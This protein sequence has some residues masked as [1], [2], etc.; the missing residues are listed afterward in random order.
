MRRGL[1]LA[2]LAA[3]VLA[4]P[5][6]AKTGIWPQPA[7]YTARLA[8]HPSGDTLSGG[9]RIQFVNQGPRTLRSVYL[10]V[11][12]NGYGSCSR[13][14]AHVRVMRGGT[15]AGWSVGCTALRV[16]FAH[17]LPPGRAHELRLTLGVRVPST[18]NRFGQDAGVVYL[19]N[20][21]PLLA[22]DEAAGPAL[23]PYTDLGDPFYSLTASWSV[24]LD[25]PAG[26]TAA[27][28]GSQTSSRRIAHGYRRLS[29][30]AAHARDFAIVIGRLSMQWTRAS[31]G[32]VL[33]RYTRAGGD[34]SAARA[35]LGMARKAIDTYTS[36]FGPLGIGEIDLLPGP[37][38]LGSFGTG[39]EFP[40]LVL[41]PDQGE[42]AAHE[43]AHQ[44]WYSLVGD[45][46]WRSPW[47]DEAFAE[48]SARRLPPS[49]VGGDALTCDE[50]DPVASYGGE[51]PLTASMSRWD[52][53][54]GDEYYRS[55]YLGGACALRVLED[56]IGTDAMTAFLRSYVAAHRFGVVDTSDFVS[57]LRAAAPAGFDVDAYLRRARIV[58]P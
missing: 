5:A 34:V 44:W 19:G 49:L 46:Q 10:R 24:R 11:W 33:R 7:R 12:P 23:E 42:T 52:A 50:T 16:R 27:T 30:S 40:G 55:I 32:I 18:S 4:S 47:L 37:R 25:V 1:L 45:D 26:L 22:V 6:G 43:L 57:A 29:I 9:E 36:W 8:W 41:T 38:S 15:A 21:L 2:V 58:A 31:S 54:G 13:R 35:T 51:G 14:Y 17:A 39:M 28:T 20:A 53:L 56:G 48:Y 3:L